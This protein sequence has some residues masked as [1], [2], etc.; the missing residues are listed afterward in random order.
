MLTDLHGSR[1]SRLGIVTDPLQFT[2]SGQLPHD[3]F[4]AAPQKC[5]VKIQAHLDQHSV[6]DKRQHLPLGLWKRIGSSHHQQE[7]KPRGKSA[8]RRLGLQVYFILLIPH[9]VIWGSYKPVIGRQAQS[10]RTHLLWLKATP[11]KPY[12][13]KFDIPTAWAQGT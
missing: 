2:S 5:A 6:K 7:K 12:S 13:S 8:I 10:V 11:R 1:S 3:K 9:Y 4:Q